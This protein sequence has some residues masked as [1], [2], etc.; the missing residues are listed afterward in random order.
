MKTT[1]STLKPGDTFKLSWWK[2]PVQAISISLVYCFNQITETADLH[3]LVKDTK[4]RF[5]SFPQ[6][7]PIE[8]MDR[9]PS[10]IQ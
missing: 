5:Y 6:T 9:I 1:A 3:T 2:S 10:I 4:N 7:M 8:T